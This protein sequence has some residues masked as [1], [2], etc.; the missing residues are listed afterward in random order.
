[1]SPFYS[2]NR[3]L[4]DDRDA[5]EWKRAMSSCNSST[6]EEQIG[7]GL[8]RY[9]SIQHCGLEEKKLFSHAL[10]RQF[11]EDS[12]WMATRHEDFNIGGCFNS[13]LS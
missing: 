12:I 3:N 13:N 5:L 1:M 6:S 9:C 8:Y 2:S 10:C 7:M 11:C 4:C